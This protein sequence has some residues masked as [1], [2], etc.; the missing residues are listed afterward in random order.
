MPGGNKDRFLRDSGAFDLV[1]AF[2]DDVKIPPYILH[3]A[4]HH[5]AKRTVINETRYRTVALRSGPDKPASFRKIHHLFKDIA[6]GDHRVI[7][8]IVQYST[9]ESAKRIPH[10]KGKSVKYFHGVRFMQILIKKKAEISCFH[11]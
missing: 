10:V 5:R 3:P 2:T 11:E 7:L 1:V 4:L 9:I 6:H 8:I